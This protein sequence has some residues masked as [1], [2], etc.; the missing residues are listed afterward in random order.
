MKKYG[1]YFLRYCDPFLLLIP[2]STRDTQ[3]IQQLFL[4]PE[5]ALSQ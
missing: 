1:K 3:V 5:W 2:L 4:E